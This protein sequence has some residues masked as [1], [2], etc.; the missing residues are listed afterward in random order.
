[1]ESKQS[2]AFDNTAV[3]LIYHMDETLGAKNIL[4]LIAM[5]LVFL[6]LLKLANA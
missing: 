6:V 2:K 5:V 4:N 3:E 1:M